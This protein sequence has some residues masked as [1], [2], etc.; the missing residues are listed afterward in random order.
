MNLNLKDLTAAVTEKAAAFRCRQRLQP[1]GGDGDKVF[2]PTYAGAVYAIEERRVK[3][4]DE[5]WQTLPCV[6]MDSVQSQANRM[7]EALQLAIDAGRFDECP[8]PLIEVNFSEADLL[9]DVQRVTSLQAPHRIADAILRDSLLDGVPFR[10]SEVGQRLGLVSLQNATPLYEVCPTALI[11]GMWDST[12]PK[13]GLGAKFQRAVVS[14]IVGVNA[15][16]GRKTS[17]RIDPIAI[18]RNAGPVY[19]ARN[20]S[21]TLDPAEAVKDR[22]EKPI[23]FGKRKG[24]DVSHD[25]QSE[26]FPDEGRPSVINHG[27]VTPDFARYSDNSSLRDP[28]SP[29]GDDSGVRKGNIAAGGVTLDYAEHFT[30]ISLPA[31]RRLRFPLNGGKPN[32]EVDAAGQTV[33]LALGLCAAALAAERGFDLRSRCLL[34]PEAPLE[35]EILAT[36]GDKPETMT[37]DPHSAIGVLKDAVAEAER[38]GLKWRK[39]KLILKPRP[40]LIAL[41]RRS[42]ELEIT[43]A[44]EIAQP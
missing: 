3:G 23:L 15:V 8:I 9:D 28:M 36:P 22:T 18:Q 7:E 32:K 25:P 14:E 40:E 2:P 39:E 26:T 33:L 13:G 38:R 43:G 44:P 17:S 34:F 12:G 24:K 21:W 31:L 16:Y 1:A 20:G 29:P 27:N 6:L 4:S 42:Q 37:I 5:K 41:V 10:E 35:W 19:R 11:F 30:V